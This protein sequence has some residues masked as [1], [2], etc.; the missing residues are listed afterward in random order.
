MVIKT[1]EKTTKISFCGE[2]MVFYVSVQ[3]LLEGLSSPAL[4]KMHEFREV[5]HTPCELH[6]QEVPR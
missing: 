3:W 2:A 6:Q 1:A 4:L 5:Q